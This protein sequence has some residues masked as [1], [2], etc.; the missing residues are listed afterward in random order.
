[1]NRNKREY[2]ILCGISLAFFGVNAQ[3]PP[4]IPD[5]P[6]A[7]N[8]FKCVFDKYSWLNNTCYIDSN[9]S[10]P[11]SATNF[12]QCFDQGEQIK[13][14]SNVITRNVEDLQDYGGP[15]TI[16]QPCMSLGD[17]Y[18]YIIKNDLA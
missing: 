17:Q 2:L 3:V 8:C 4:V 11:G 7:D 6:Q 1:M 14:K 15:L 10:S 5:S 18:Y 16:M 9:V 13:N 12:N